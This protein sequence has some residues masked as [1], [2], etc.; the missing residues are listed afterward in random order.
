MPEPTP[1]SQ[2]NSGFTLG[3]LVGIVAGAAVGY[4]A[5][6]DK[7]KEILEKLA[8]NAGLVLDNVKDKLEENQI[9]QDKLAAAQEAIDQAKEVVGESVQKVTEPRLFHRGGSPLKP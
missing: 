9:V 1:P 4:F 5:T 3:L 2:N 6:T 7:G 8:D